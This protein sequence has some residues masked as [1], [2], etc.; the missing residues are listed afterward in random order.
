M[1]KSLSTNYKKFS[2][3]KGKQS[4]LTRFFHAF[5]PEAV[6]R[7]TKIEHPR[8]SRKAVSSFLK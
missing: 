5:L 3:L 2:L 4:V 8:V 6:Y 1:G 7:N